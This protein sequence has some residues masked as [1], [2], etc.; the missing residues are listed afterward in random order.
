MSIFSG[1]ID[2]RLSVLETMFKQFMIREDK[3]FVEVKSSLSEI[4][5]HIEDHKQD[6]QKGLDSC[7]IA[8]LDTV[9]KQYSTKP[10][11][12]EALTGLRDAI[13]KDI[14][15]NYKRVMVSLWLLFL[16]FSTATM[17]F[18]WVYIYIIPHAPIPG[19]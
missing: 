9:E 16:G 4:M 18:A 6:N 3:S 8:I 15:I 19:T 2:T 1:S 17:I 13:M 12:A 10:E 14:Q 5:Q 7:R 11:T